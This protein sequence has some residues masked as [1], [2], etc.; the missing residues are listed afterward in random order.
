MLLLA[1]CVSSGGSD[2]VKALASDVSSNA[3][4]SQVELRTP[5]ANASPTFQETFVSRVSEKMKSCAHGSRPLKLVVDITE[6]KKANAA[7]TFLVGSS[8][9]IRGSAKLQDPATSE[10]LADFDINRSV[11]GGGLIAMAAMAQAEEQMSNAF[12][13]ELCKKAFIRR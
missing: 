11:G 6:F 12:G 1:A 2:T 13:D 5:P 3:F 4:V 10:V 9:N 8:N 7:A